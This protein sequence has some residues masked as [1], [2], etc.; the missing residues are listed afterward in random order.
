[1]KKGAWGFR[2]LRPLH[3][4][5]ALTAAVIGFGRIGRRT[6]ALFA[7]AGFAV[8]AHDPF[9]VVEVEA[10]VRGASLE[11]VLAEADVVSLH[12]PARVEGEPMLGATELSKMKAG[13]ILV[14]T[15]RGSLVDL[16]SLVEGLRKGR[17][18]IAAL[19]VYP[20]EPP[21]V[22]IFEPVADRL[23]LSPHMAWYTE[24]SERDLRE[25]AAH[26]ARRVLQGERPL[27]PVATPE[28]VTA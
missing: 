4:P 22:T 20:N 21:D 12:A 27:N 13:S 16:G 14:N 24:E 15:A 2:A 18:A 8:L 26:E 17:P 7:R 23:V 3:L 6:A 11:E 19:D 28:G 10:G 1:V 5:S 25:K 9:T